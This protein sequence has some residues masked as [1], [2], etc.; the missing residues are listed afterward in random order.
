MPG[1]EKCG[2]YC[3]GKRAPRKGQ[4]SGGETM[5]FHNMQ[6]PSVSC[7]QLVECNREQLLLSR[8]D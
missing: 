2:A 3:G 8:N 1:C 4:Y 6:L 5:D 7:Q